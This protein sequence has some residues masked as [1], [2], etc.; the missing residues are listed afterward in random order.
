MPE[1]TLLRD[2]AVVMALSGV[3][4]AL[5]HRLRQPVVLGYV[6]AG[7][8][9]GPSASPFPL[10]RDAHSIE[11]LAELGMIL[12]LFSVGLEF[13]LSRL[14][15]V[16]AAAAIGAALEMPLMVWIGYSAG[17]LAGLPVL[18]S[19]FLGAILSISSTTIIGKSLLDLGVAQAEFARVVLGILIFEDIAAVGILALLSGIARAG[20]VELG[21]AALVVAGVVLFFVTVAVLGLLALPRLLRGLARVPAPE[22]LTVGVLG[23]CFGVSIVA[24]ELGFSPA[25]GAFVVGAVLAETRDRRRIAERIEPIRDMFAAMFFVAVGLSLDLSILRAHW[26]LVLLLAAVTIAGKTASASFAAIVAGY[27][28]RTALRVGT[29]LAQI[30]EFSFVIASL[31]RTAGVISELLYPIA[32]AVSALTTF[33][34]PYLVRRSDRLV[35]ALS[36]HVPQRLRDFLAFYDRRL[37]QWRRRSGWRFP[38]EIR[39]AAARFAVSGLLLLALLLVARGAASYAERILPPGE[40]VQQYAKVLVW[41]A[42]GIASLPL[43]AAFWRSCGELAMRL[44]ATLAGRSEGSRTIAEAFR[45]ALTLGAA[46]VFLA[47]ASPFF[48]TGLPLVATAGFVAASARVFWKSFARVH[49]EAERAL[50]ELFATSEAAESS[51]R[52][53]AELGELIAR[54]YPFEVVLEDFILPVSP[55]G[56]N[57]SIGTLA[58]RSRTGATIVAI[59]RED[60]SIVGPGPEVVLEPGDVVL[61]LGNREQIAAALQLLERLASSPR[62]ETGGH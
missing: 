58:L 19:L 22:V 23:L 30:G 10:V 15:R 39:A 12:L 33:A 18:D 2:L 48:P 26:R 54:K 52:A 13:R 49:H 56:A 51:A 31:G 28:P 44:S 11:L 4:T 42:G 17:R 1:A 50:A 38:R 47:V 25:L 61:L 37:G 32:V 20:T 46:V 60:R 35:D 9:V 57:V 3:V 14:R 29:T 55:T 40:I 45:F 24:A 21:E 6:L 43:V 62:R 41:T 53:R 8:L 34:V 16:G 27:P 7:I 5:F 59:Y 36:P